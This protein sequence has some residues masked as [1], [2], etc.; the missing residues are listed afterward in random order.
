MGSLILHCI[1]FLGFPMSTLMCVRANGSTHVVTTF[2]ARSKN[3][4]SELP[5]VFY[6]YVC[7]GYYGSMRNWLKWWPR[8]F[9]WGILN[10]YILSHTAMQY[11]SPLPNVFAFRFNCIKTVVHLSVA[12]TII[13]CWKVRRKCAETSEPQR[14]LIRRQHDFQLFASVFWQFDWRSSK[15]R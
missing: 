11:K 12:K 1:V 2:T 5:D 3:W 4:R 13:P 15:K 8:I 6:V 7:R 9:L 14:Q 10:G